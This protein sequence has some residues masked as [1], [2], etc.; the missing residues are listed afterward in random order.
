MK[1]KKL[2]LNQFDIQPMTKNDL[3]KVLG[4]FVAISSDGTGSASTGSS[5]SASTCNNVDVDSNSDSD[6]END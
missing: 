3:S 4:G 1:F 6:S 2:K 5:V